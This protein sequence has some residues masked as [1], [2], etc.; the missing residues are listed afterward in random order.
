MRSAGPRDEQGLEGAN[1]PQEVAAIVGGSVW[2]VKEMA[3]QRRVPH[4]RLGRSKIMFRRIDILALMD[5]RAVEAVSGPLPTDPVDEAAEAGIAPT[6]ADIA[7]SAGVTR[8]GAARF[9]KLG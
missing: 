4:L 9:H 8:R 2:W 7:I 5:S 6:L 3:R 1:T